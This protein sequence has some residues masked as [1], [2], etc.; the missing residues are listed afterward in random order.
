MGG[1]WVAEVWN[2]PTRGPV[3][4]VSWLVW[5]VLSIVLHELAHGW[6][7][8][9]FGDPTPRA[10]GHM[11]WNPLVHMGPYSLVALA[12]VGLAWGA[13]PVDPSR[14]RGRHAEPLV[15][16][17]GPAMNLLLAIVA[18]VGLILWHPFADGHLIP[19]VRV[20]DPL[21]L[22]LTVFFFVGGLL[23]VVLL[24]FNLLPAVPLDGGRIAAYYIRPYGEFVRTEHGMWVGFGVMILFFWFAG[25]FIF[26]LAESIVEDGAGLAWDLMGVP[27]WLP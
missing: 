18:L 3:W 13:M 6:A 7:A 5:V 8:L 20:G 12:L 17:A 16:A 9:R 19:S 4:V 27:R 1:W 25:G 22:N 11:T 24:I 2:Q 21:A 15:L 23:N 14:M 10:T 26:P